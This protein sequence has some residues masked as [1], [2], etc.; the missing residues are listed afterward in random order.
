[1]PGFRKRTYAKAF[2]KP[3]GKRAFK[4]R[5][6]F[7][8]G[9]RRTADFTSLNTKGTSVGFRGKKISR[10]VYRSYLWDSTMFKTHWRSLLTTAGDVTTPAN[11]VA[12]TVTGLN[13]YRHTTNPFWTTAGG[14]I[15]VDTGN[16]L[17]LF[18]GDII[19]RGGVYTC[20]FS[21][22]TANDMVLKI[23]MSTT[24]GDPSLAI[25][26]STVPIGWDPSSS[27]DF[28]SQVAKTWEQKT[29]HIEGGNSYSIS[30]RFKL[31]KIDSV[32]YG[33]EGLSPV[34]WMSIGNLGH[35][36][37]S[38]CRVARSYNLS[39]SADAIGTT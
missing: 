29:V 10:R 17:P 2:K 35:S 37:A 11:D 9:G 1:M 36:T 39:F 38:I 15:V 26:P 24:V 28:N 23:W 7:K 18:S 34:I 16:T 33:I 5:R 32:T 19:L 6:I 4:R 14:G 13:M 20:T 3:Y 27:P 12:A 8:K 21:N 25:V 30:K 22:T 31:Q